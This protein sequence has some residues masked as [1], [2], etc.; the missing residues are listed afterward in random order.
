MKFFPTV[1][2]AITK[3]QSSRKGSKRNQNVISQTWTTNI[4][5]FTLQTKAPGLYLYHKPDCYVFA[6]C[7]KADIYKISQCYR[8][9]GWRAIQGH[10]TSR[11]IIHFG[12]CKRCYNIFRL[13]DESSEHTPFA[14]PTVVWRTL[15][16]EWRV[17]EYVHKHKSYHNVRNSTPC[18]TFFGA[19]NFSFII[20]KIWS[21]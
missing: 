4:F 2:H 18:A 10:S 7:D 13:V 21:S 8:L 19:D 5:S 11:K 14:P 9:L 12:I 1:F 20:V 15:F 6:F 3:E 17:C 16:R